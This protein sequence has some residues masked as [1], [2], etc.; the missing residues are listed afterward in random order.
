MPLLKSLNYANEILQAE[1]NF[2]RQ[3]RG[4]ESTHGP[5]C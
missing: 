3:I 1:L 5:C 2:K 4:E